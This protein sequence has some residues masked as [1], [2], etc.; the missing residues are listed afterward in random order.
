L[1]ILPECEGAVGTGGRPSDDPTKVEA[2][3]RLGQENGVADSAAVVVAYMGDDMR[4]EFIVT[5]SLDAM[6]DVP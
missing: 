4:D 1:P 2:G 6:L 5:A 3:L